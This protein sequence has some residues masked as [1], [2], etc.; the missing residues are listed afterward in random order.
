M[1]SKGAAAWYLSKGQISAGDSIFLR[2]SGAHGCRETVSGLGFRDF[3]GLLV[4]SS[5]SSVYGGLR[6][7][8]PASFKIFITST[9]EFEDLRGTED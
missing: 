9:M 3:L 5:S 6:I 4:Q 8:S 7:D 1:G 2:F